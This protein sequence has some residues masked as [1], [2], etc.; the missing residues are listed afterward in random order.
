MYAIDVPASVQRQV[1]FLADRPVEIPED[2]TQVTGK[3]VWAIAPEFPSPASS[4]FK[5]A[6]SVQGLTLYRQD[7]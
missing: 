4:G 1:E 2:L 6:L 7:P 5:P 3:K